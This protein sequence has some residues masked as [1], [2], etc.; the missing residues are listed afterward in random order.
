VRG[1]WSMAPPTETGMKQADELAARIASDKAAYDIRRIFSSDLPRAMQ[2]AHPT[3]DMLGLE[4]EVKP[5]FRETNNGELAGMKNVTALRR[6]PG[7]FWNTLDW[8]QHYPGGESPHEFYDRI[9]SAWESLKAEVSGSDGNI[10]LVT[11]AGVINVIMCICS[12]RQFSNKQR[13]P[14]IDHAKIIRVEI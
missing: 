9:T 7:M 1:G 12:G 2:T 4:I 6:F 3:A 10:M 13:S 8:D 11:H 5:E 14:A